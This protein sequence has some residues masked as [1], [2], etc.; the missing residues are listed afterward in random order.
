MPALSARRR[1]AP[2]ADLLHERVR[3]LLDA[4]R[5]MRAHVVERGDE[6][7]PAVA[8]RDHLARDEI[9]EHRDEKQR[10]A[11]RD[12]IERLDQLGRKRV[13]RE[14]QREEPRDVVLRD[15]LER[16]RARPPARDQVTHHRVEGMADRLRLDSPRRGEDEQPRTFAARTGE[17]DQIQRGDIGPLQIF[18]DEHDRVLRRQ[19]LERIDQLAHHAG[20]VA[21]AR[22]LAHRIE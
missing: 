8:L 10:R 20:I 6:R 19:R 17:R 5:A 22:A 2:E 11:R 21:I 12:P 4:V 13:T 3:Q 1:A 7:P 14:A 9:V 15:A 18:E 16:H